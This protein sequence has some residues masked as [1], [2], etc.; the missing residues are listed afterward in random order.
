M[1][2]PHILLEEHYDKKGKYLGKTII[3]LKDLTPAKIASLKT[4]VLDSQGFH[5]YRKAMKDAGYD[6]SP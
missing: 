5:K 4:D 6:I 2:S 1:S 3:Y